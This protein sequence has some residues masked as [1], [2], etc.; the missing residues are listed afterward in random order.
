MGGRGGFRAALPQSALSKMVL[1]CKGIEVVSLNPWKE[2]EYE[3]KHD[4]R[5]NALDFKLK[6]I[7]LHVKY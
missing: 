6:L 5:D 1:A 2:E 3:G 7:E 4:F